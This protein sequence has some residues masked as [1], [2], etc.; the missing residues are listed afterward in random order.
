MSESSLRYREC[1]NLWR[2]LPEHFRKKWSVVASSRGMNGYAMFMKANVS[3][4]KSGGE[5]MIAPRF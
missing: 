3:S 5:F 1:L 4:L 2:N